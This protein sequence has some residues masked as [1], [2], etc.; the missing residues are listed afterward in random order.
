MSINSLNFYVR[1]IITN[2]ELE[3]NRKQVT[4]D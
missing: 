4:N 2:A 1:N 3:K